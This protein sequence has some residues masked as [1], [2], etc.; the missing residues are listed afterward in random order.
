MQVRELV[1]S[2]FTNFAR[3]GQPSNL[4]S[5]LGGLWWWPP[6]DPKSY[7]PG[8]GFFN[9]SGPNSTV[10]HDDAIAYRMAHWD[11]VIQL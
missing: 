5:P 6:L 7:T 1:T 9:I 3:Y 4:S 2:A 11:F 10:G 8:I